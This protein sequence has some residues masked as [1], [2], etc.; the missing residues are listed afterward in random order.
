MERVT[1]P[2]PKGHL[3]RPGSRGP[4]AVS[5]RLCR[6]MMGLRFAA[7]VRSRRSAWMLPNVQNLHLQ[8]KKI[9]VSRLK[10]GGTRQAAHA[11]V[12]IFAV[13]R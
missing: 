4:A 8:V 1:A 10:T 13:N 9:A 12:A 2:P 5:F 6:T 11:A 7:P 3:F